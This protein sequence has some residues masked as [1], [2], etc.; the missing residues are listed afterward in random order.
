M[1]KIIV[2]D[3][4]V[5]MRDLISE[6]VVSAGHEAIN[7]CSGE[8]LLSI[9][10]DVM[11]D[12]VIMDVIMNGLNGIDTMV[13]ILE[14]HPDAKFIICSAV[15]NQSDFGSKALEKGAVDCICK[16]FG[17]DDLVTKINKVLN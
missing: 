12:V 16:P 14:K 6:I 7:V 3:D 15:A 1:G 13:K 2:A 5:F 8:E 17:F 11:P 4:A 10:D 9:Y